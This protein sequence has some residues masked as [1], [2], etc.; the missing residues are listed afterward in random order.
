MPTKI[1]AVNEILRSLQSPPI[2][3]LEGP[4]DDDASVAIATLDEIHQ[5]VLR[6]GWDFNTL[7]DVTRSPI[8]GEIGLAGVKRLVI[9]PRS[10]S[11]SH[12]YV[13]RNGRLYDAVANS[14]TITE[15]VRFS[16]VVISVDWSETPEIV[17]RY[18][19][20]RAARVSVGRLKNNPELLRNAGYEELEMLRT[21]R[22]D[23]SLQQGLSMID[24]PGVREALIAYPNGGGRYTDALG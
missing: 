1:E 7:K 4:L 20:T 16:Q 18:V 19:T 13:N 21:V 14:Y 11:S 8:S 3:S 15:S 23:H 9:D 24:S 2:S 6:E 22:R 12:R 10:Q 5:D 17:Q